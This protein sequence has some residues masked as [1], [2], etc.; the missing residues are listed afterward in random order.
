[1]NARVFFINIISLI[2]YIMKTLHKVMATVSAVALIAGTTAYAAT[3]I[4]PS[5]SPADV[6]ITA[7]V[8]PYLTLEVSSNSIDMGTL[9]VGASKT[10]S[11]AHTV[12]ANSNGTDYAVSY[13]VVGANTSADV[14]AISTATPGTASQEIPFTVASDGT[15]HAGTKV[16]DVTSFTATPTVANISY[17]AGSATGKQAGAYSATV[18]YT[19]TG[20]Y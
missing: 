20:N 1:M 7:A 9:T 17:T 3:A 14:L 6:A 8:A 2:L 19:A 13:T 12:T 4:T 16:I 11:N 15:G 5:G 10:V 18:T